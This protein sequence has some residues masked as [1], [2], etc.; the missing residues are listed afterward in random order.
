M[1]VPPEQR[2]ADNAANKESP[3]PETST[4]LMLRAAKCWRLTNPFFYS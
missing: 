4:G 1:R 3:A 2:P